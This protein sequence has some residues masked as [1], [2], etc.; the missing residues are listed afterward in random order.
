[1]LILRNTLALLAA[2]LLLAPIGPGNE[3]AV[4]A[5]SA[6]LMD[7]NAELLYELD[8]HRMLPM[9]STTKLMTALV[10]I[11]SCPLDEEVLIPAACCGLEGSSMYLRPGESLPVRELL[12]GLLLESG[13]DAAAALALHCAG[14]LDAFTA[15]MNR[16][17]AELGMRDTHFLNPHGLNE[18]G[19][20]STAYDLALLM[21]AAMRN[22]TFASLIALPSAAVGER[23]LNNHNKLLQRCDG[24]LGGKT[25]FTRVAGRCLVSCAERNGLRL[26]CVTLSDPDDWNDHIC[27]YDWA[28]SSFEALRLDAESCRRE[29]PL[30]SGGEPCAAAVPAEEILLVL[31]KGAKPELSEQLP[32]YVFAPVAKGSPAGLLTVCEGGRLLAEIPLVY[33]KDYPLE[34]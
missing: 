22:E 11:E 24:C 12:I 28:F 21:R 29:I 31:H 33:E 16:R 10:V 1:M 25:G 2:V 14:D 30:L 5:N 26:F 17:A 3:P 18:A 15:R 6:V 20:Y 7:E 9:A 23:T 13:N 8:A 27:L 4:S 32:F 34:W 19:H